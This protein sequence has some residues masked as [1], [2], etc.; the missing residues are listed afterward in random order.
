VDNAFDTPPPL[1]E[2][3][4]QGLGGNPSNKY[5]IFGHVAR[6][7]SLQLLDFF[8]PG[9][10][11]VRPGTHFPPSILLAGVLFGLFG[12][13]PVDWRTKMLQLRLGWEKIPRRPG[14]ID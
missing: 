10:L 5:D 13:V 6:G 7:R 9:R 12:L 2:S 14:I 3:T 11:L 8:A 4:A 1:V